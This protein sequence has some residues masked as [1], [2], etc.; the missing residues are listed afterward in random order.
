MGKKKK[1]YYIVVKGYE[2]GL[3]KQWHGDDGAAVQVQGYSNP[4]YKGFYT[5][6]DAVWW[7]KQLGEN[8]LANLPADLDKLLNSSEIRQT[9]GNIHAASV[10][11]MLEAGKIVIYTDGGAD[12]NPGAG[13]YGIVLRFQ[14]HR[15]ELSGGVRLTTNNRMELLACIEGLKSVKIDTYEIVLFSDSKYVVDNIVGS[16][17]KRWQANGWIRGKKHKVKNVDLWG[18][19]L[20]LCGKYKI[21]F[22]WLKGHAGIPD[23]ERCD[24]LATRA[25]QQKN[26][27]PDVSYENGTT[28]I[29][30]L[31]LFSN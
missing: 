15:K 19:L 17:A 8:T 4:I 13:G 30:V 25:I 27:P 21:K 5:L 18:Q 1:Q 16:H 26:L 29:N 22:R 23:N 6:E 31:P 20:A 12:P 28:Q 14:E 9:T 24:V 3:Y 7:M 2:P 10:K 11:I